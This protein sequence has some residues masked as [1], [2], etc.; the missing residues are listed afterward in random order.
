MLAQATTSANGRPGIHHVISRTIKDLFCRFQTMKG[1]CVPRKGGWDTHGLPVELGVEKALGIVKDDIGKKISIA[2][3]N[4]ACR[5]D[6]MKLTD[7]WHDLT[8]KMGYWVDMDDPYVTYSNKYIESTWYLTNRHCESD[9]AIAVAGRGVESMS[10]IGRVA[11]ERRR[12]SFS[13]TPDTS[14]LTLIFFA[15]RPLRKADRRS[16]RFFG[17]RCSS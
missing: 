6:V 7:V 1:R 14:W 4:K 5:E 2:D 17:D 16:D 13:P 9:R 15:L 11:F 12:A 8:R 3:F 10:V